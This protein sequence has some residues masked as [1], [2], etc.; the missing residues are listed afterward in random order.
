M[1]SRFLKLVGTLSL[2]EQ[3]LW[4]LNQLAHDPDSWT[5]P[6]FLNLKTGYDILVNKYDCK[7]QKMYTVQDHPP[8]PN[9]SLLI[10][11]LDILHKT[12]V[13]SQELSQP[14]DSRSVNPPCQRAISKQMMKKW[15][16]WDT[17]TRTV[18]QLTDASA[19]G[20]P[21]ATNY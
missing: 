21:H 5:T 12:H 14:G 11:P 4:L 18:E 2:E 1:A 3:K 19:I 10:P 8:S 13:R 20:F 17:N 16:P 15:E 9:D 7:V 6:D